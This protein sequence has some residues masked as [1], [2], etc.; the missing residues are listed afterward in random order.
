MLPTT[1]IVY[2]PA[3]MQTIQ[4]NPSLT[5]NLTLSR[6]MMIMTTTT[7]MPYLWALGSCRFFGQKA[8]SINMKDLCNFFMRFSLSSFL[9]FAWKHGVREMFGHAYSAYGPLKHRQQKRYE[10]QKHQFCS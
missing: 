6:E 10:S 1:E 7:T 4:Y 5:I 3:C 9:H 2:F 8:S